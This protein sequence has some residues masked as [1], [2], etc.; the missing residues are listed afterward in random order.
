MKHSLKTSLLLITIF[1]T[2]CQTS[3]NSKVAKKE[4][5][6][7]N[8]PSKTVVSTYSGGEVT[9]KDVNVELEKLIIKND[10][11]KGITFDKLSSD[12]KEAIIKEAVLKEMAYKEA[13]KRSLNKDKEYRE[14]IKLF[15]SEL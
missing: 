12:Q 4:E 9:L 15:E 8:D 1:L 11:L 7:A 14:A 6:A 3:L 5:S 13:K 10:K 2:S